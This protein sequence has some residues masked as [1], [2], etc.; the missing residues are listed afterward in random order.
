MDMTN[1]GRW[2]GITKKGGKG[3]GGDLNELRLFQDH[4]EA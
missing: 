2:K 3:K 1:L 4:V